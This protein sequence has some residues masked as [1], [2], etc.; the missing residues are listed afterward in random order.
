MSGGVVLLRVGIAVA[1]KGAAILIYNLV[2]LRSLKDPKD[3]LL[4]VKQ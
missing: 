2:K 4:K 3:E 1:G